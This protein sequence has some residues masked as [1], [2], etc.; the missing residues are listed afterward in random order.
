LYLYGDDD[1]FYPLEKFQIFEQK[2]KNYL[3]NFQAESYKA[4][5]EITDGMREEAKKW[6]TENG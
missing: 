2:L 1:E 5:H 6:I 3:P 4:K